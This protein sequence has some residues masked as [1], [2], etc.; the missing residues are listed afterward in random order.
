MNQSQKI[1]L[2]RQKR[3]AKTKKMQ[4]AAQQNALFMR[5]SKIERAHIKVEAKQR[6]DGKKKSLLAI[7]QELTSITSTV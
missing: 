1:G 6:K 7:K 2:K 4:Y 5:K 3:K